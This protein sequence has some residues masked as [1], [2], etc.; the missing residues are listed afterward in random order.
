MQARVV[1]EFAQQ[2]VEMCDPGCVVGLD[3]LDRAREKLGRT[4]SRSV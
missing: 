2:M 3:D 1:P 4:L